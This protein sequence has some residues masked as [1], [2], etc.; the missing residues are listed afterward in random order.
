MP[1]AGGDFL[2]E[3]LPT[4]HFPVYPFPYRKIL[5]RTFQGRKF[6]YRGFLRQKFANGISPVE[7]HLQDILHTGFLPKGIFP[8]VLIGVFPA[9]LYPTISDGDSPAGISPP[10]L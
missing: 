2:A 6:A 4:E 7:I 5:L 9:G 1:M 3:L 8:A 10:I